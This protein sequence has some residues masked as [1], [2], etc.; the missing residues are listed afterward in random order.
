[1]IRYLLIFGMFFLAACSSQRNV[2]VYPFNK[3]F[4]FI[5]VTDTFKLTI[6]QFYR[7]NAYPYTEGLPYALLIGKTSNINLPRQISVLAPRDNNSYNL[8]DV[9]IINPIEAPTKTSTL[10]P[11]YFIKD[12]TIGKQKYRAIIGAEHPAVWANVSR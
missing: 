4:D 5:S 8:G 10:R 3:G 7:N 1:M 11:I 12:T 9:V 2:Q 6:T